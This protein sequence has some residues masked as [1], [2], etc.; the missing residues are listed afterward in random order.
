MS[1]VRCNVV[2]C[3]YNGGMFCNKTIT[4]IYNGVCGVLADK[5]GNRKDPNTWI[6][7]IFQNSTKKDFVEEND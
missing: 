4:I 5:N 1:V 6:K 7:S 2:D 3:K